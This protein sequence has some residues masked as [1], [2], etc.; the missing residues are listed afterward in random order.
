VK[1]CRTKARAEKGNKVKTNINKSKHNYLPQF[2]FLFIHFNLEFPTDRVIEEQRYFHRRRTSSLQTLFTAGESSAKHR[3]RLISPTGCDGTSGFDAASFNN[4]AHQ[5]SP[6]DYVRV[7]VA[8]RKPWLAFCKE[9]ANGGLSNT[10]HPKDNHMMV[11]LQKLHELYFFIRNV[12]ISDKNEGFEEITI[13][14][15]I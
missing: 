15:K 10:N 14:I 11:T 9:Q 12:S 13:Q 6:V 3:R 5:F 8:N 7:F 2:V 4:L 1:C